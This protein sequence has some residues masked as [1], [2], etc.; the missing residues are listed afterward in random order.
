M[1]E[2]VCA[3][4]IV[5]FLVVFLS[6]TRIFLIDDRVSVKASDGRTFLVRDTHHKQETAETLARLNTM[7]VQFID[8]LVATADADHKVMALRLSERYNPNAL[9]ESRVE[10][11]LTSFTVNK[12][13]EVSL[14]LRTRDDKEELHDFNTIIYAHL[15]ELAHVASI[16]EGHTNEFFSN[17]RYL[18]RKSAEWGM[19][20]H[21][22]GPMNYCG[23]DMDGI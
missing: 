20:K 10:K 16:S 15:H 11:H 22:K 6:K 5:L 4:V 2:F 7:V 12:G 14:C 1:K 23:I 8:K 3:L 21:V 9:V 13:E 19:F 18:L 17:F